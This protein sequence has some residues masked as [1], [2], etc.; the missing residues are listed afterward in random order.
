[1]KKVVLVLAM[2]TLIACTKRDGT[3]DNE[4]SPNTPETGTPNQPE[5][6][7]GPKATITSF[8][9]VNVHI[10]NLV[11]VTGTNLDSLKTIMIGNI[12]AIVVT[13]TNT[14]AVVMIMPG[15]VS[16]PINI[17]TS[18]G[19]T[20]STS[21]LTITPGNTAGMLT[22]SFEDPT[23]NQ[24]THLIKTGV[25][26]SGDG[27]TAVMGVLNDN[28]APGYGA[29]YIYSKLGNTWI[30][31]GGKL[32]IN[33]NNYQNFGGT[34]TINADGN[35]ILI[36]AETTVGRFSTG[37][38]FTRIEGIWTQQGR[39]TTNV[40]NGNF[41]NGPAV[42][43]SADGNTAVMGSVADGGGVG[44]I[45]VFDRAGSTW[46]MTAK[47]IGRDANYNETQGSSVAIS[48]D[49]STIVESGTNSSGLWVF[50]KNNGYWLQQGDVFGANDVG[51]IRTGLGRSVAINAD[52]NTIV[53][54][55]IDGFGGARVFT[56]S[57]NKWTQQGPKITGSRNGDYDQGRTVAVSADGNTIMFSG[58]Y[59]KEDYFYNKGAA[60]IFKRVDNSWQQQTRLILPQFLELGGYDPEYTIA[61]SAD[62][63]TALI[64]AVVV[65][66]FNNSTVKPGYNGG[67]YVFN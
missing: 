24:T 1:M 26:V 36:S 9:P 19:S 49:G 45:W 3:I 22:S 5:G 2:L 57:N 55:S 66:F 10:G 12:G 63:G 21:I 51:V 31:Q 47:L 67:I 14:K 41:L 13:K 17:T 23:K 40:G 32:Y 62:G 48:A 58:Y 50:V 27:K 15:S 29:A 39:I 33:D 35:T 7:K 54:G 43:L 42:S 60:W 8:D 34:V 52:G 28:S 38:V 11:T 25:A 46:K 61:M 56:R 6:H 18:G 64:S 44:A 53:S 30:Q 4:P 20:S 37:F 65:R 16:A 59:D